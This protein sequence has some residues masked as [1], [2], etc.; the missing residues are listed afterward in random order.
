MKQSVG[1]K[2]DPSTKAAAGAAGGLASA[3]REA[4]SAA[5]ML[6][7][8]FVVLAGL[9]AIRPF[10][11]GSGVLDRI[12]GGAPAWTQV[13]LLHRDPILED[14]SHGED[15]HLSLSTLAGAWEARRPSR[16]VYFMG[17]S[18]MQD[19]SLAAG[20]EP[21]SVP[22]KTYFYQVADHYQREAGD[23]VA[24]Y[25][26][27]FPAISYAEVLWALRYVTEV[28]ALKPDLVLVQ[29]NY[30][31][32]RQA[33]IRDGVLSMLS[34]PG[35]RASVE[36]AAA[37]SEPHAEVFAD[38]LKRYGEREARSAAERGRAPGSSWLASV[39]ALE[40][41]SAAETW[42]RGWLG[43]ASG[44]AT[45]AAQKD[46]FLEML[47][48]L[49]LYVLQVKPTTV[50]PIGGARLV[51]NQS[52]LDAIAELCAQRGVRLV[53]FHAPLNPLV[54]LHATPEDRRSYEEMVRSFAA[55]H[56]LTIFDFEREV[57]AERWGRLLNGPDPMHMSRAGH[58]MLAQRII[59]S[60][61]VESSR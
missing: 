14:A 18:Q 46:E 23:R 35:F 19:V 21:P 5:G 6:L 26:L 12:F 43:S 4:L 52:A 45:R 57:P 24:L 44:F 10:Q 27:S 2:A 42:A 53:L 34:L 25:R 9:L 15:L 50:R 37:G 47:Y 60:G 3:P 38:A 55:R 54:E 22:E 7:A 13:R 32:F 36:A 16:R 8:T 30:Q 11:R 1:A 28:P 20:E 33:G 48:R 40:P 59:A 17:N 41:G 56:D 51:Q 39:A 58:Q 29:I 49:R 31:A 61:V